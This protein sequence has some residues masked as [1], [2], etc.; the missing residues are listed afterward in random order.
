MSVQINLTIRMERGFRFDTGQTIRILESLNAKVAF[1]SITAVLPEI[2]VLCQ[3][4]Y[5]KESNS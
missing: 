3:K 5:P 1:I 2:N 4:M